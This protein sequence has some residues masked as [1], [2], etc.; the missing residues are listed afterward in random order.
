MATSLQRLIV[1]VPVGSP[2]IEH[3]QKIGTWPL[4]LVPAAKITSGKQP[5]NQQLMKGSYKIPF[6]DVKGHQT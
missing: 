3:S 6:F 5:F 4:K 2:Y 1:L